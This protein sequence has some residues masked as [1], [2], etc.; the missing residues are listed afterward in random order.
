MFF[1]VLVSRQSSF[2]RNVFVK[3]VGKPFWNER[4]GARSIFMMAVLLRL[5]L[6]LATIS[7]YAHSIFFMVVVVVDLLLI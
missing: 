5:D 4:I 1:L 6:G 7:Q 3:K 2:E